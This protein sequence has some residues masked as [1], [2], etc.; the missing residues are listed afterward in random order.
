MRKQFW[1]ICGRK[2]HN[3]VCHGTTT[4]GLGDRYR[5]TVMAVQ[6]YDRISVTRFMMKRPVQEVVERINRHLEQGET[7]QRAIARRPKA[8]G[9]Q[10]PADVRYTH[11]LLGVMMWAR[12]HRAARW[13]H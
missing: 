9:Y 11:D 3:A 13:V 8:L 5:C 1:F 12:H 6:H 10:A 4:R 2:A 7:Q